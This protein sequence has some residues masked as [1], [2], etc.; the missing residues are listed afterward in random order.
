METIN[1]T[2]AAKALLVLTDF[3]HSAKNAAGYA[4]NL[5][6]RTHVDI[7]LFNAYRIPDVGFDSWPSRNDG[8]LS[9][10]SVT[11]LQEETDR[12]NA[13]SKEFTGDFTPKCDFISLEGGIAESVNEIIED[14]KNILMVIM[15]GGK[16]NG[17]EDMR[18]GVEI[19]EVLVNVKCPTLIIPNCEY[20]PF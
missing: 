2:K 3:S 15:G 19:T 14:R 20:V 4:L 6:L 7:V 11:K 17:R 16:A 9:Q 1:E 10:E 12:M 5:A 8:N 18:F 13:L